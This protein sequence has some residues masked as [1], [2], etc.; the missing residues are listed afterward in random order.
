MKFKKGD[1]VK[2]TAKYLRKTGYIRLKGRIGVVNWTSTELTQ[3]DFKCDDGVVRR[4][5]AETKGHYW[6]HVD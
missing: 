2:P 3:V 4:Y 6:R 1:R 5:I